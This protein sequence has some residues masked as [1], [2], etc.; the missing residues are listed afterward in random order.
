MRFRIN[1]FTEQEWPS[2]PP[3]AF[4]HFSVGEELS[5]STIVALG[6]SNPGL[7]KHR[8]CALAVLTSNHV[9]SIWAAESR[10]SVA[11]EW[12]RVLIV[13][14]ELKRASVNNF[15]PSSRQATHSNLL[16]QRIRSFA[17]SPLFQPR[18]LQGSPYVDARIDWGEALLAVSNSQKEI[19]LLHVQSPHNDLQKD[20]PEWTAS[21][22]ARF[23]ANAGPTTSQWAQSA[24]LSDFLQRDA[25]IERLAW[26]P[27]SLSNGTH[28]SSVLAYTQRSELHF[29]YLKGNPHSDG[30]QIEADDLPIP[31]ELPLRVTPNT[32]LKWAPQA[33]I[34][35]SQY[36]VAFAEE[37]VIC[38]AFASKQEWETTITYHD[39]EGLSNQISGE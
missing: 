22:V 4:R 30:V 31:L 5:E 28:M 36:L 34:Q 23:T 20:K 14:K 24:M 29:K 38:I 19:L 11:A 8:R 39:I 25:Y 26:S 15:A 7:A 17:W 9:L 6:W 35:S 3:V 16:Q 21:V 10:V 32:P 33:L 37:K 1:L 18:S 12:K 13:N 27:W 2:R